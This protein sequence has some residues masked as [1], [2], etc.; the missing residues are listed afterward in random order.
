VI[1]ATWSD[2]Y[3]LRPRTC[4]S[5]DRKNTVLG[6]NSSCRVHPPLNRSLFPRLSE[7]PS[8]STSL[9]YAKHSSASRYHSNIEFVDSVSSAS[10]SLLIQQ[11]FIHSHLISDKCFR[12]KF[13]KLVTFTHPTLL[14][15]VWSRTSLS[16][17][18]PTARR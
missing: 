4:H 8:G 15:F 1:L 10:L 7:S 5:R 13:A 9:R 2:A 17:V 18:S 6:A 3:R 12:M 11:V 14:V 16:V